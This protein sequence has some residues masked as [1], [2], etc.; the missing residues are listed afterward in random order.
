MSQAGTS[1]STSVKVRFPREMLAGIEEWAA[2]HDVP[3]S[4]AIRVLLYRGMAGDWSDFDGC[5][6]D[7][8]DQCTGKCSFEQLRGNDNS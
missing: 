5:T 1:I 6:C 4:K 8:P 7:G 3:P 2:A